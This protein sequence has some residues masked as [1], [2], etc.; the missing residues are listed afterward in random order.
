MC[1]SIMRSAARELESILP[2]H[3]LREERVLYRVVDRV[4]GPLGALVLAA[5]LGHGPLVEPA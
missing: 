1:R 5:R 4:L 3:N 2:G